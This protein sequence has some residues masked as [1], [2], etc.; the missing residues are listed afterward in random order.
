MRAELEA[1]LRWRQ[2]QL[3]T[4]E[5]QQEVLT[6]RRGDSDLVGVSPGIQKVKEKVRQIAATHATVLLTGE[7]GVGK[8]VVAGA[9]QAASDRAGKPFVKVNVAALPRDLL[10]SELFGHERGAFTS[11]V[12]A[13]K[14]R[15]ELADGGTIFLD[16]IAECPPEVQVKLLRVLQE[17]EFE[18]VGGSETIRVD[19]R[20]I[21]ATNKNLKKE[22]SE[23]RFREDLYFRIN[24]IQIQIPPLRERKDDIEVLV[25]HFLRQFSIREGRSK[26]INPAAL[27]LMQRYD[28][29]G[30]VRELRNA[31]EHA[32][33]LSPGDELQA[34]A[35]P[36]EL[37]AKVG[38]APAAPSTAV[39]STLGKMGIAVP[40]A[41]DN[42]IVLPLDLPMEEVE[43]RFILAVY[44]KC[45]K[46]KTLT[47]KVL[48]I[49]LKTLYRKLVKYGEMK[50]EEA[51]GL[52]AE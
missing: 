18:R 34:D 33:L 5:L 40:A 41:G 50:S 52:G 39:A 15:F 49:G 2:A 7:S 4:A 45:R 25:P 1:A 9:I 21:C 10:E 48:G 28:W 35:L 17:Q 32:W 51:E 19:V 46:N 31:I 14:G 44:E 26:T 3:E 38:A 16:E 22:M 47:H 43:K 24:V 12:K 6:R 29:P 37:L 11:A 30:N 23:G 8:E 20:L 42:N 27:Q 13:R 36:D